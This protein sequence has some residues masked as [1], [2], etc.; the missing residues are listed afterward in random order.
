MK[1][2]LAVL[3]LLLV[4]IP[5]AAQVT[6]TLTADE[7]R[8]DENA[9][10]IPVRAVIANTS[11]LSAAISL[12]LRIVQPSPMQILVDDPAWT[13]TPIQNGL[14]CTHAPFVAGQEVVLDFLL[15]LPERAGR[16][17]VSGLVTYNIVGIGASNIYREAQATM[18]RRFAVTNSGDGNE[19]GTLRGEI[20]AVNAETACRVWP[21]R[22]EIR[23]PMTIAP[24][25]QLPTL[26]ANDVEIDA[27]RV[28]LL[29]SALA[30][31]NGLHIR[32]DRMA[33]RGLT[34]Q[35][36]PENGIFY[37][38]RLRNSQFVIEKNE[39]SFN[40]VRGIVVE[41]GIVTRSHIRDNVISHNL[42]SGIFVVTST[43]PSL[44][45]E[46]VITIARNTIVKN[47]ASG[48]FF[49]PETQ[50]M[51][52]TDN[53]IAENAHMGVSV[54]RGAT[55]IRFGANSIFDNAGLAIDY[56]LDGPT[57]PAGLNDTGVTG[58]I[59]SATYDAATN[60]TTIRGQGPKDL[61][62]LTFTYHLYA[63]ASVDSDGWAEAERFLGTA[64]STADGTFTLVVQGDLRGQYVTSHAT[65]G[66]DQ[67]FYD[68][69]ELSRPLRV[70]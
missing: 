35:R 49:G 30:L 67:A 3:A 42:R 65:R 10:T 37:E 2:L 52:T 36:F 61:G 21:C 13:C 8:L 31:G 58:A 53:V 12:E 41:R 7:S 38:P 11:Q 17:W 14:R 19:R 5:A 34:I 27:D 24:L 56:H 25:T 18:W 29:G 66:V 16:A 9:G 48:I 15:R 28:Q 40:G 6:F 47:G 46:P 4:S 45:L 26:V 22:I 50:T 64:P 1:P 60:T 51:L 62:W 23:G 59:V 55:M 69:Y 43:E 68:T 70:E 57:A 39:I 32:G 63:N 33:V 54:A 44:P 20:N